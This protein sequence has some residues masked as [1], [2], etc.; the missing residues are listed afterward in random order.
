MVLAE[1]LG[2]LSRGC[3]PLAARRGLP[4]A[5]PAQAVCSG[6]AVGLDVPGQEERIA[7]VFGKLPQS[8]LWP[9][10]VSLPSLTRCPPPRDALRSS[11]SCRRG[12]K[13]GCGGGASNED[14]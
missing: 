1:L 11:S 13:S 10:I 4:G 3:G 7:L 14:L 8:V 12:S 2:P 9:Q 5:L 6:C